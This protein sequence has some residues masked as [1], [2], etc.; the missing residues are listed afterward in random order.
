[1]ILDEN[2]E[3][4]DALDISADIGTALVGDVVDL[5][6]TPQDLGNGQAMYLV[7]QVD[8]TFTTGSTAAVQFT[9]ASDATASIATN[10]DASEHLLTDAFD[11][12]TLVEGITL[13]LPMPTGAGVPYERYLGV[14][15]TTSGASTTAGKV[16][17]F[18][19]FDPSHW[20]AYADASN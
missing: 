6:A 14:L 20:K 8:T 12:G 5:G 7:I 4:A 18:L 13:V 15:A 17:A 10:G 1:M 2:L 16:N 19:T 11:T 9:L 3:F